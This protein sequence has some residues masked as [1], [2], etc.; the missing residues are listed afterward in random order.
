[1]HHDH[2]MFDLNS[3]YC[4]NHGLEDGKIKQ[5]TN[6]DERGKEKWVSMELSYNKSPLPSNMLS[7]MWFVNEKSVKSV[8]KLDKNHYISIGGGSLNIYDH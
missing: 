3:I 2:M 4:Y 1:M 8:W 6:V 5:F 7:L